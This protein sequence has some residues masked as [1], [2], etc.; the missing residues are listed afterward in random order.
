M[1]APSDMMDGRVEAIK[2]ALMAHG[3]GN[4]VGEG[5]G[6]VR[7]P[8]PDLPLCLLPTWTKQGPELQWA[9]DTGFSLDLGP[10][11]PCHFTLGHVKRAG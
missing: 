4:R 1:V 2:E 6:E 9:W 5:C 7:E 3:F 11:C 10:S 8:G